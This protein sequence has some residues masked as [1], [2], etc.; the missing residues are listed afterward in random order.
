VE[1]YGETREATDDNII[2][3]MHF[4]CWIAK[5]T[6]THSEYVIII[7]FPRQNL[8]VDESHCYVICLIM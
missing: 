4:E 1:K 2:R 7:A 5:A 3:H 8:F 6:D